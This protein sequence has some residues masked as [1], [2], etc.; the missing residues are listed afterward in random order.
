MASQRKLL[1]TTTS[2]IPVLDTSIGN[3]AAYNDPKSNAN[4]ASS[5][6]ILGDQLQ[7]DRLYDAPSP[8]REGFQ[9]QG[10]QGGTVP[11]INFRV[12]DG[13][14]CFRPN[15]NSVNAE[16]CGLGLPPP[17]TWIQNQLA[18]E[19]PQPDLQ[20]LEGYMDMGS[21]VAP[22]PPATFALLAGA[23]AL[24]LCVFMGSK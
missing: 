5:I 14:N 4:M 2:E 20:L 12:P 15:R 8:P 16:A 18:C 3:P 7:A 21:P 11:V 9:G 19:K 22:P 23:A 24:L 13:P 10:L 17:R 1:N 6:Q